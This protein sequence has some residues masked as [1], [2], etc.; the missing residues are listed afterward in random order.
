MRKLPEAHDKKRGHSYVK[1]EL[2]RQRKETRSLSAVS[3]EVTTPF[4]LLVEGTMRPSLNDAL[5][6][7]S[8]CSSRLF[9][10]RPITIKH[11]I[12]DSSKSQLRHH[13]TDLTSTTEKSQIWHVSP[14]ASNTLLTP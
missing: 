1:R 13:I 11:Q 9:Y 6:N 10:Q 7:L 12:M 4:L 5:A 3:S 14:G 8:T 2:T